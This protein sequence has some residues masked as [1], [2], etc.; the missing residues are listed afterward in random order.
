MVCVTGRRA[1][2]LGDGRQCSWRFRSPG[3]GA[4]RVIGAP[5]QGTPSSTVPHVRM[6]HDTGCPAG[7]G[8][9]GSG[10]LLLEL[11]ACMGECDI[12]GSSVR[13]PAF[14]VGPWSHFL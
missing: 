1:Q 4:A 8:G 12:E 13:H 3:I 2:W 9:R 10:R 11:V 5:G 14:L 7:N 6:L